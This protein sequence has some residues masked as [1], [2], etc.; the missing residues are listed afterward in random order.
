MSQAHLLDDKT[1]DWVD[2]REIPQVAQ[3]S[4]DW[5]FARKNK[6]TSSDFASVV[7]YTEFYIGHI[8]DMWGY[9][10]GEKPLVKYDDSKTCG[11]ISYEAYILKKA[12][13]HKR[14]KNGKIIPDE[15]DRAVGQKGTDTSSAMGIGNRYEQIIKNLTMQV[16]KVYIE[17]IG[18]VEELRVRNGSASPDGLIFCRQTV[19]KDKHDK[20]QK[21]INYF[22]TDASHS[23]FLSHNEIAALSSGTKNFEAKT[24]VTREMVKRIP[25]KYHIQV[26]RTAWE[27]HLQSSIYTEAQFVELEKSDWLKKITD[28][29]I[30]FEGDLAN[31]ENHL[32]FGILLVVADTTTDESWH[33]WPPFWLRTPDQFLKWHSTIA[34]DYKVSNPT[35]KVTAI[36]FELVAFWTVEIKLWEN[37]GSV[38]G[39][40]I[41]SEAQKLYD[42]VH[43]EK[44]RAEYQK[45]TDAAN[46]KP[47]TVRAK[48]QTLFPELCCLCNKSDIE[49]IGTRINSL[50]L[51]V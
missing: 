26:E 36:Y 17:E 19:E 28:Y 10:D 40:L 47:V 22:L 14:D 6:Q 16:C 41:E 34:D 3:D 39:P 30:T 44:G 11:D 7:P 37:Y 4:Y 32:K 9:N 20:P 46:K 25:I 24:I 21:L 18:F 12:F 15:N 23:N 31:V 5:Q 51:Q 43:T 45:L 1:V 13:P 38:Y 2:I 48:K 50:N 49:N 42:L 8:V 35:W 29:K 33:V 27:L